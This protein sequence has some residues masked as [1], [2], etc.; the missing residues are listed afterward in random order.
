M[1]K[2]TL[3]ALIAVAL[4]QSEGWVQITVYGEAHGGE[5]SVA[6]FVDSVAVE[7]EVSGVV[8][9]LEL[10]ENIQTQIHS[11]VVSGSPNDFDR[12]L[13][14]L[15]WCDGINRD[16]KST[17]A[18]IEMIRRFAELNQETDHELIVVPI[19]PASGFPEGGDLETNTNFAARGMANNIAQAA[20]AY[21][22]YAVFTLLGERHAGNISTSFNFDGGVITIY[23]V[24]ELLR[25]DHN[26]VT[27]TI[28]MRYIGGEYFAC[29]TTGCGVM[30][31]RPSGT[32]YQPGAFDEIINLG[33][34]T[35]TQ[36]ISGDEQYCRTWVPPQ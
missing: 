3:A 22:E 20:A 27:R 28:Y 5:E 21:P 6:H 16:A 7:L 32:A 30:E 26:L 25:A 33:E 8:V 23:T 13:E 29:T 15:G 14:A 24:S 31:V 34:S 19:L 36:P 1:I 17:V 4:S 9:A 12:L 18:Y 35:P 11:Y 2:L 10:S